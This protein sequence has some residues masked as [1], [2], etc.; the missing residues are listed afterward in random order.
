MREPSR[1]DDVLADLL[2]IPTPSA[3]AG[4]ASVSAYL[5]SEN[6]RDTHEVIIDH[7][8]EMICWPAI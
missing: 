7:I 1:A 5:S 2:A 6:M 3:T 4:T 8:R